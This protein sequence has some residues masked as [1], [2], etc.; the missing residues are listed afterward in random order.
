LLVYA[1]EKMDHSYNNLEEVE[2]VVG[3]PIIGAIP[4]IR[5]KAWLRKKRLSH[6]L[7]SIL[8]VIYWGTLGFVV[9]NREYV[10]KYVG[11][12]FSDLGIYRSTLRI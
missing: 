9:L 6:A 12:W 11:E 8:I 3:I 1:S 4:R 7:I 5:T 10:R 2:Q